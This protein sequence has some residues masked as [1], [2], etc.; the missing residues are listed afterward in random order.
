VLGAVLGV[1]R[2]WHDGLI[3]VVLGFGAGALI[4]SISFELTAEGFQLG[5]AMP[6]ALGIAAGALAFFFAD[7]GVRRLQADRR[8]GWATARPR[9][10]ARRHSGAGR[11]RDR[12]GGGRGCQRGTAGGHFVSNLPEAIGSSTDM[13]IGSVRPR[14]IIFLWIAVAAGV[15]NGDG[16]RLRRVASHDQQRSCG[17]TV[18]GS[19]E[20]VE[21]LR[22]GGVLCTQHA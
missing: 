6:L 17:E 18:H 21:Q 8:S 4:S 19:L 1:A 12:F 13:K 16:R 22:Q 9:R 3:G 20:G 2:Q 5:G 10:L 15:R 7:R 11:P 14:V